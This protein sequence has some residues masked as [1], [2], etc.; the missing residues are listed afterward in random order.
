M[1]SPRANHRV[2]HIDMVTLV[3]LSC[4]LF[5]NPSTTTAYSFVPSTHRNMLFV[6]QTSRVRYRIWE[7]DLQNRSSTSYLV[8]KRPHRQRRSTSADPVIPEDVPTELPANLKR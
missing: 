5:I 4:T 6:G 8:M 3:V 7:R 1:S 2:G